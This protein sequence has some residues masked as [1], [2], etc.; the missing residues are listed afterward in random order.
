MAVAREIEATDL[1]RRIRLGG[2]PDEMRDLADT[3]DAM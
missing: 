3:F 1:S 2:P